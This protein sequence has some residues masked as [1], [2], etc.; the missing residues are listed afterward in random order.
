MGKYLKMVGNIILYLFIYF[1]LQA[2]FGGILGVA[3]AIIYS[4]N[5]VSVIQ[6][7]IMRYIFV[8]VVVAALVSIMIYFFILKGKGV[9]FKE[10]CEFHKV[11]SKDTLSII[12]LALSLGALST[13]FIVLTQNTFK[14]YQEVS[15]NMAVGMESILGI[16]AVIILI[17]IF[18]E[19]LF[20]GLIFN[21][22]K[23]NVNIIISVVLQAAIFAIA[24]GNIA[25]A[26][27]AFFL[28]LMASLIYIWTKSIV[29][30]MLLHITFN[31]SGTFIFPILLY[32]TKNYV[33]LY[34]VLGAVFF[35]FAT[36]RLYRSNLNRTESFNFTNGI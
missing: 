36:F 15:K 6:N 28:G 10:R 5:S 17:P 16:I 32:F 7:I 35:V 20:R 24:H 3:I 12:L 22:L 31:L 27:Y 25:Q 34:I 23:N 1:F 14:S 11:K 8:S 13:S 26:I 18:E 4:G 30:N 2:I 19:I 9:S 33:V 21:E 29:S